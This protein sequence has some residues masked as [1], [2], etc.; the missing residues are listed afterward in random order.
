MNYSDVIRMPSGRSRAFS[1]TDFFSA[2]EGTVLWLVL[3]ISDHASWIWVLSML[4]PPKFMEELAVI[5]SGYEPARV[6]YHFVR[7]RNDCGSDQV[8][9]TSLGPCS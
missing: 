2:S 4:K 5:L 9:K 8:L 3:N 7:Q 6:L 1:D